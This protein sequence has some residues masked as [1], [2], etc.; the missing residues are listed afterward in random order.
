MSLFKVVILYK[1]ETIINDADLI[2]MEHFEIN[3]AVIKYGIDKII[4]KMGVN[5]DKP[6]Q[7]LDESKHKM[8]ETY[9]RNRAKKGSKKD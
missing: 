9:M 6:G 3:R 4:N 7:H 5:T 1:C 8:S 2:K